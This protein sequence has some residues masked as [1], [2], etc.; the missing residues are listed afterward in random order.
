MQTVTAA[1]V[2]AG[3]RGRYVYGEYA[4]RHPEQ[5]KIVAVAEPDEE[6]RQT[7]RQQH[8]IL[9]ENCFE[10]YEALFRRPRMAQAVFIC[11]QDGMHVAPA[12]LAL[13]SGYHVLLEKPISNTPEECVEI[14]RSCARHR[15]RLIVI[16]H[17]LRYT[18]FFL[19]FREILDSGVLGRITGIEYTE[20]VGFYHFAHSYVR[21]HWADSGAASPLVLAKSCHD[22]DILRWLADSPVESLAASGE[23]TEFRPENRPQGAPEY[24]VEGCPAQASCPYNAQRLYG[25]FKPAAFFRKVAQTEDS[26]HDLRHMLRSSDYGR[27]VYRCRNNVPDH[28]AIRLHFANG[29]DALFAITAFSSR[30]T[31][32]LCIHGTRGELYGDLDKKRI[33]CTDFAT[34]ASRRVRLDVPRAGHC[35]GDNGLIGSFV[36]RIREGNT[37][38]PTVLSQSLESHL[39]AFAVERSRLEKREIDFPAFA[40]SFG[41]EY[42]L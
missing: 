18:P 12:R 23:L 32:T 34:M 40:R 39:L 33:R 10:S 27:C 30:M 21:G 41:I 16:A 24:C 25:S 29:V 26:E 5:L 19:T 17:V 15:N 3:S 35:G 37:E 28:L 36:Q 1:I 7:F 6:K 38:M 9:E 4:R 11:T 22:L 20:N 31:R 8:G 14:W 2:G 42:P 13:E